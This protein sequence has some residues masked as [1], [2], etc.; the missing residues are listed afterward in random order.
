MSLGFAG[1]LRRVR[2]HPLTTTDCSADSALPRLRCAHPRR[3]LPRPLQPASHRPQH[4]AATAK[5]G[6]EDDWVA[7]HGPVCPGYGNQAMHWSSDLTADHA[8]PV[9][10]GGA[11]NGALVVRC[12]SCNSD[13]GS[14]L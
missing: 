11:E 3:Q 6:R 12:R 2:R 5:Q 1:S 14:R 13:R 9:A 7:E 8:V 4:D 10:A